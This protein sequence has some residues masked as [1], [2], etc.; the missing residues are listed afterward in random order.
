MTTKRKNV[1]SSQQDNNLGN[2]KGSIEDIGPCALV[3]GPRWADAEFYGRWLLA[4]AKA[5]MLWREAYEDPSFLE[6]VMLVTMCYIPDFAFG[7]TVLLSR[8]EKNLAS[9]TIGLNSDDGEEFNELAMMCEMGFL[10]APETLS[11]GNTDELE[12]GN[13]QTS[14]AEV[15]PDRR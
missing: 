9:V 1:E 7:A 15:R 5:E 3:E 11:D 10:A 13:S 14:G 12:H 4:A 8:F 2:Q 6:K